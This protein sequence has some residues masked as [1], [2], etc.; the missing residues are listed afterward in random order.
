[1]HEKPL[2]AYKFIGHVIISRFLEL[3][4]MLPKTGLFVT[5]VEGISRDL[6]F[7]EFGPGRA[8]AT[9]WVSSSN[10]IPEL[11]QLIKQE[12]RERHLDIF[13]T[14]ESKFKQHL[15]FRKIEKETFDEKAN[16]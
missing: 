12:A 13:I 6:V 4:K 1:M 10:D 8:V 2:K 3:I 15:P 14:K 16:V 7:D 5:F 9:A 11:I